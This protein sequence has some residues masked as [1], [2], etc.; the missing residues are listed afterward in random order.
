MLRHVVGER[1]RVEII[2]AARPGPDQKRDR[3]AGEE[4]LGGLCAG[5]GREEQR[6]GCD[7]DAKGIHSPLPRDRTA[8]VVDDPFST[9]CEIHKQRLPC[10]AARPTLRS[11]IR[12]LHAARVPMQ[13][14]PIP[15]AAE[16]APAP[17]PYGVLGLVVSAIVILEIG[18]AHV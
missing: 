2:A 13:V 18:R 3:F 4:L 10:G 12:S 9:A 6:A 14:E 8:F 7:G 17:R 5:Y 1:A 16:A 15:V 11:T